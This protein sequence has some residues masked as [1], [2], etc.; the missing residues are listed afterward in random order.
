MNIE[1]LRLFV[2]LT[3]TR[4]IS[5]A[6]QE[7]GLSPAVASTHIS[8]LEQSLGVRLVHRTTRKVSMTEEGKAFLPHAEEVLSSVEA[9]R[10]AVGGG[11]AIPTG[12]LRVAAPASFGRMHLM[13]ALKTFLI[14]YPELAVD[15][16]FSD[17][18][19]D[20]VEG[21]FDIAIRNAELEDSTLIARKLAPDTRRVYASPQYLAEH[22]EPSTPEDLLKH[23]C[24]NL[25][26]LESWV[27]ETPTG[28][29]TI[30]TK[31]TLRT[32][33][34]EVVRDACANGLGIAFS[35]SWCAYQ[36]V[37]RGELV[38]ILRDFPL[39][40]GTAIWAVYP[41]SRLLA[42]KVRAFIDYFAA[43]FGSTPYWDK[44]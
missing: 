25:M 11:S 12:T 36:H 6:G 26:G 32:D 24:I 20:L 29:Q 31:G 21:G 37:K 40:S 42:P 28:K 9:A 43:H 15:F 8:K 5:V 30:K 34:G 35:S 1:H 19:V 14:D 39:V 27:F 18:I 23:E 16:R 41:T 22:G 10:A 4:N 44:Q 7:L 38:P 13:P 2:R 3:A 33:N 17:T